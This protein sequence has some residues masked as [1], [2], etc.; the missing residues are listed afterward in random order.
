VLGPQKRA[1]RVWQ[2][3]DESLTIVAAMQHN[4]TGNRLNDARRGALWICRN[5]AGRSAAFMLI[6]KSAK[7]A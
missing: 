5:R 7:V 2:Q 1:F 4:S 3:L 6:E